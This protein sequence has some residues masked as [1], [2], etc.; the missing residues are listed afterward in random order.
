M[1]EG[2]SGEPD[3]GVS[4]VWRG[5]GGRPGDAAAFLALTASVGVEAYRYIS[6]ADARRSG[7][8]G[9]ALKT[10]NDGGAV[11]ASM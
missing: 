8:S 6:A 2:K 4:L 1:T 5:G 11:V 3:A 10:G 9:V 7:R